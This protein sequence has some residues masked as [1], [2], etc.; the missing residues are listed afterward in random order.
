MKKP[1]LWTKDFL[2]NSL[3][4]FLIFFVY[5]LLMVIIAVYA[6]DHLNASPSQAGLATGIFMVTAL[7]SRIWV[8]K[9]IE[10][11]GRKKMLYIGFSIYSLATLGY[12]VAANLPLL[13]LIRAVH[14]VGFG[15]MTTTMLTIVAT[16]IPPERR[17]EGIGYFTTSTTVA[18]AIGPFIGMFLYQHTG[19]STIL[20]GCVILLGV[21]YG[22]ASFLKIVE[23]ELTEGQIEQM[24]RVTLSNF[25]EVKVLPIA[26][27]GTLVFFSYSSLM[28]FLPAYSREIELLDAGSVFFLVYSVAMIVSRPFAGRW[29]DV[30]GHNA[31]MY[32][33]F[34]LFA[35]GFVLLSQAHHGLILL[36]A[37]VF[38]GIGFGTFAS[39]GQ[40]IAISVVEKHRIG[41][42]TATFLAI[43]ETGIGFG[44]FL[45]G[46]LIPAIG[47]RGMYLS[48]A[49]V[50]ILSMCFY[51]V[52]HGRHAKHGQTQL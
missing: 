39:S 38:M 34:L 4:N 6:M 27:I 1:P 24:K 3:A 17:G 32:P 22:A 2:L 23:V 52:L 44:P 11:V 5:Y 33:S 42:A 31:V 49:G 50:V 45:L 10:Q 29:F 43:A 28:S 18:S 48:M 36:L 35:I 7:I 30:K 15:M 46:F 9:F 51:Y 47:F 14:G 20:G 26:A 40:A 13:V 21:T 41:V 16:V 8:G 19:F 12:F 25:F 37:G